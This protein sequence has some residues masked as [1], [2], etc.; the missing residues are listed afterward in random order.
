M[1]FELSMSAIDLSLIQLPKA[2]L[3]RPGFAFLKDGALTFQSLHAEEEK[4]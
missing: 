3:D 4:W 2:V 1:P